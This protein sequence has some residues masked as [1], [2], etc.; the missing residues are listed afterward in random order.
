MP[1]ESQRHAPCY[2]Q[3]EQQQHAHG[4]AA[5][6]PALQ[7]LRDRLHGDAQS[8]VRADAAGHGERFGSA[9]ENNGPNAGVFRHDGN[10]LALS[11]ISCERF[12]LT[13]I[14][15]HTGDDLPLLIGYKNLC[16]L[17]DFTFRN[18]ALQMLRGFDRVNSV[19]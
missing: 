12:A 7:G 19:V 6:A 1:E 16:A 9:W 3:T 18:E 15:R 14:S 11:E 13:K 5:F 4:P 10:G 17:I 2:Q 8:T